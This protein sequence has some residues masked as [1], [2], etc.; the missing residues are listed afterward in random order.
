MRVLIDA[1]PLQTGHRQ[2]GV[3]TYT[4]ELVR[5]L[6]VVDPDTEYVLIVHPFG[7]RAGG[8]PAVSAWNRAVGGPEG[9]LFRSL[10]A[11][12]GLLTL[13]RP[14][15]GKFTGA[16]SHQVFLPALLDRERGDLFHCPGYVAAFSVPGVPW[17]CRMPLVLT[18]HDFIPLHVPELFNDKAIN[19][20]WYARQGRLAQHAARL[21]CVSEATRQD[22]LLALGARPEQ[23][24]VVHE[25]VDP[26]VFYPRPAAE[27]AADP[28]FILFVGGDFPNKNRP[29][30]LAA[31]ARLAAMTGLP[32]RLVL[33][34]HDPT[35]VA[36]LA[37][38]YPTLDLARVE[39]VEHLTQAEL[40]RL[41][42]SAD[43]LLFPST[44]EGFGLP[45]LEA[46][47]SG[48]PV[49]TSTASSLPEVAGDAAVLVDPH[50]A[51][52]LAAALATLLADRSHHAH[53]RA[54]G[55]ARA[56]QFTWET[57]ARN[58]AAVYKAVVA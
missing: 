7:E 35:G 12:V 22:A 53:L 27:A 30:A 31:F 51:D 3:G 6:P 57:M 39:R 13:P 15:A 23:C 1:T 21:I 11:N 28:P 43:V 26:T 38:R 44:C 8:L 36:E 19:R 58:T 54:A 46:M 2:R 29:A 49:I 34:G 37:R 45:V 33:V 41:Y 9:P 56:R 18:L 52:A 20:W 16:V 47:A 25:G 48:T 14:P 32:H 17:R 50:D 40:A 5:A 10:P 24:V 55:L 4:R 42:R